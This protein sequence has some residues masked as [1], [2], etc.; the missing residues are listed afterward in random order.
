MK[1]TEQNIDK[2]LGKLF[3]TKVGNKSNSEYIVIYLSKDHYTAKNY[4]L[5]YLK[6]PAPWKNESYHL[7]FALIIDLLNRDYQLLGDI[8]ELDI[9]S[10]IEEKHNAS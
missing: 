10:F 9:E 2:Y 7:N 8:S 5:T 1:I 6:A 4:V 3:F